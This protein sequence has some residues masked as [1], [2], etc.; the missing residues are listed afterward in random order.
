M[1]K[2]KT[3]FSRKAIENLLG[4]V[5]KENSIIGRSWSSAKLFVVQN[6]IE[7]ANEDVGDAFYSRKCVIF[8]VSLSSRCAHVLSLKNI[9]LFYDDNVNQFR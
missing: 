2:S 5:L 6:Y 8:L 7:N 1:V 9:F 4:K 3:Y